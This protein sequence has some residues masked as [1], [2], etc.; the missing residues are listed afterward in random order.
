MKISLEVTNIDLASTLTTSSTLP[1][2]Q[3]RTVD[4]TVIIKDNQTVVIGGLI[5]D[6]TTVNQTGVPLLSDIPVLGYLFRK[7]SETNQKTNLYIFLTPR[8]IKN[9]ME[10]Q[11]ILKDKKEQID[12]IKEGGIKLYQGDE[13]APVEIE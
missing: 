8:V 5:D 2:T 6:S 11:K 10:A 9:P 7:K 1:V 3:K 12:T 4:T 13:S